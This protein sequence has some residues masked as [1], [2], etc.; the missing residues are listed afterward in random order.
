M[1]RSLIVEG[2]AFDL[3]LLKLRRR[4]ELFG[5][6][7]R[8]VLVDNKI[9]PELCL[10]GTVVIRTSIHAWG[11]QRLRLLALHIEARRH[12]ELHLLW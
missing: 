7:G 5:A 10:W 3:R 11:R 8:G 4:R 2:V 6:A 1:R 9:G 12:V